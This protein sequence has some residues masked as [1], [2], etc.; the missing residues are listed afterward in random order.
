MK[1][2]KPNKQLFDLASFLSHVSHCF[3]EELK[4]YPQQL[5]DILKKYA[6]VL[7][8]DMRLVTT[9]ENAFYIYISVFENNIC[10]VVV[11]L[12][13]KR[14]S[15]S[16]SCSCEARI[17]SSRCR[18]SRLFLASSSARTRRCDPLFTHT[19]S[20]MSNASRPSSRTTSFARL[21]SIVVSFICKIKTPSFH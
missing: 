10:Y 18:F 1:P 12:L 2:S 5:I 9:R 19:C 11:F 14:A 6:T 20:T 7:N 3:P 16:A 8:P 17:W 13:R 15:P 21:V 4:S